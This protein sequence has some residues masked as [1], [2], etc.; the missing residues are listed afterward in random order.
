M[1]STAAPAAAT[2]GAECKLASLQKYWPDDRTLHM[3]V[4]LHKC[5]PLLLLLL[6]MLQQLQQLQ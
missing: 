1:I 4:C 6:L 5:T 2:A 3:H